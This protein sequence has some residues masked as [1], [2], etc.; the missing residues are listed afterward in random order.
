MIRASTICVAAMLALGCNSGEEAPRGRRGLVPVVPYRPPSEGPSELAEVPTP[1]ERR[2]PE[3]LVEDTGPKGPARDLGAEL[4]AAV[5]IP[6]DCV[7]DFDSA[8]PTTIRI[9]VSGTVR[10][11]GMV[12][13]PAAYGSGLS[14]AA[15][16][17]IEQRVATVML[18]PLDEQT[19]QRASTVIEINYEPDVIVRS[20]STVPE[21][22]L[23]NVKEPLPKRPEVAPSGRPIS[24]PPSKSIS[25]GFEGGR[26]IQE[27]KS[28][29]ISGPKPRPIDGYTV[30]ENAQEW[31]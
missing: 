24:D 26:P 25:G 13:E 12:I 6:S 30:D 22:N 11:T 9:S 7:R 28:K 17:C 3:P 2:D 29:K 4:R 15:R 31:R 5:G 20:D 27:P 16:K 21:P 10:P 1:P 14:G 23:K 19:S 18:V 8:R